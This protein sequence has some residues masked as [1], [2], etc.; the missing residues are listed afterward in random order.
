VCAVWKGENGEREDWEEELERTECFEF[1]D[2]LV[3]L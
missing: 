3:E 1:D 2:L